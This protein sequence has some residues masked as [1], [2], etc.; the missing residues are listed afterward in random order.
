VSYDPSPAEPPDEFDRD[1]QPRDW[2]ADAGSYP[3]VPRP[4]THHE[5]AQPPPDPLDDAHRRARRPDELT[6]RVA[7]RAVSAGYAAPAGA[8]S[9][10]S[11]SRY[12]C[13]LPVKKALTE[14][15]GW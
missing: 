11:Q 15:R 1:Y 14:T 3:P 9:T 6:L 10:P 2:P 13:K 5:T 8:R 12:F 4:R 7:G